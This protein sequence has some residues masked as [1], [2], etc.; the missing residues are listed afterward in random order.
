[1]GSP[2]TFLPARCVSPPPEGGSL[3]G[4]IV[5]MNDPVLQQVLEEVWGRCG[6]TCRMRI[7]TSRMTRCPAGV[8]QSSAVQQPEVLKTDKSAFAHTCQQTCYIDYCTDLC[9]SVVCP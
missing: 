3:R 7:W 1:M 5:Q 9:P 8:W 6:T 2:W 4:R